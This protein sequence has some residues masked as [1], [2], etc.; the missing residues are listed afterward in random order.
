MAKKKLKSTTILSKQR[1]K[2]KKK[3][4]KKSLKLLSIFSLIAAVS[5][6]AYLYR[7]NF[8]RVHSQANINQ[9]TKIKDASK[10]HQD[11]NFIIRPGKNGAL[12]AKEIQRLTALA[13]KATS[14]A[15][16]RNLLH[17]IS[18]EIQTQSDY[19]R[20]HAIKTSLNTIVITAVKRE[21]YLVVKADE[22]RFLS[23]EGIVFG[24]LANK[25]GKSPYISVFG[26]FF[27]HKENS[28]YTLQEDNSYKLSQAEKSRVKNAI[29]L[30]E[31]IEK[32]NLAINKIVFQPYRGFS[33]FL[34]NENTEVVIGKPPYNT[35]F[36]RLKSILENMREKGILYS[37]IELDYDGKAFIKEGKI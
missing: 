5:F 7:N 2:R 12:E 10:N 37:K 19:A 1:P 23:K 27:D 18:K 11:F 15:N 13:K 32:E 6:F 28:P 26:I 36:A 34:R 24:S 21:P 20:V 4:W 8:L 9:S 31:I 30:M 16:D 17:K 22:F 29:M 35:R 33:I 3:A 25:E 14:T